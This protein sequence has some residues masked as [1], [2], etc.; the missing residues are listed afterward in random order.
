MQVNTP[1]AVADEGIVARKG[2]SI[3]PLSSPLAATRNMGVDKVRVIKTARSRRRNKQGKAD[4]G[5]SPKITAPLS[6][7]TKDLTHIPIRDMEAWVNRPIEVRRKEVEQ[8]NGKIARPMNSFMLYRSAYAERT[9][10][11]CAQNNHQVVSRASGQSWPLEPP[12][13]REKFELLAIIERDNHQKAHPG[14]KFAPNKSHT[15]PKKKR[16]V[17][18]DE[19]SDLDDPEYN[20]RSSPANF[21][22][23]ARSSEADS[24]YE[25]RDSTP[26]DNQ[27]LFPAGSYNR[28]SWQVNNPGRP[29]PGM[30][31]PPEQ[32]HYFQPSIH[33]SM[34]GPNVEDVRLR[35]MGLP[36][37][38]YS[39]TATLAGLPGSVHH[40]LLQPQST[41]TTPG[42]SDDSQLDPQLL[43]FD[44]E[45]AELGAAG[46]A[47][48]NTQYALWQADPATNSY[49]PV[50]GPLPSNPT[51]YHVEPVYHPG[52]QSVTDGREIWDLNHHQQQHHPHHHNEEGTGE[53]GKEFD[54]WL[55]TQTSGF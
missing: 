43:A 30:L 11:W 21:R 41:A 31:S 52:I 45:S 17:E 7:L 50:S 36:G 10:E 9:K 38:Q 12:E 34:M 44:G 15:P 53:A 1:P 14:Y 40:E 46:G 26:F 3:P 39:A 19:P 16:A 28:S 47:Y 20:L 29:M 48:S 2:R 18:E 51:Q 42:Q 25:S 8:K 5:A 24:C 6:E 33:P 23:R 55:N 35:K 13:I 32:T 27:D 54:Q 49:L 37:V 4:R 22:K